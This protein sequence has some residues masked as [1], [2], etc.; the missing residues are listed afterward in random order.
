MPGELL[1]QMPFGIM[2]FHPTT[3]TVPLGVLPHLPDSWAKVISCLP[4]EY[5]DACP[6]LGMLDQK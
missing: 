6:C 5:L 1:R 4:Y 3:R 2:E